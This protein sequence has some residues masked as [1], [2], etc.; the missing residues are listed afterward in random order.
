LLFLTGICACC[1]SLA[2]FLVPAIVASPLFLNENGNAGMK[3]AKWWIVDHGPD[4]KENAS[5]GGI[6]FSNI[7]LIPFIK[8]IVLTAG[9]QLIC[10][11]VHQIIVCSI[12]RVHGIRAFIVF[13]SSSM[14]PMVT[15]AFPHSS[16]HP[17][18]IALRNKSQ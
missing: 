17:L 4:K 16:S 2:G 15:I 7:I 8:T 1:F 11:N 18:T 3:N 14:L 12:V 5:A 9:V 6:H 13:A 10:I